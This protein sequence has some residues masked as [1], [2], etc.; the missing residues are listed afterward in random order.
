MTIRKRVEA[1]LSDV[2]EGAADTLTAL[3]FLG[4]V[5]GVVGIA[6]VTT[7]VWAPLFFVARTAEHASQRKTWKMY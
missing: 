6:T 7:P 5:G 2:G 3:F 1:H 4:V